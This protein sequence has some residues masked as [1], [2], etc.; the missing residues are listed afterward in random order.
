[1]SFGARHRAATKPMP[2]TSRNSSVKTMIS[3]RWSRHM[4]VHPRRFVIW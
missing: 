1:M 2:L 4:M 3:V